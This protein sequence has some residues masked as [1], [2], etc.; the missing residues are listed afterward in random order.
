MTLWWGVSW[1]SEVDGSGGCTMS[2]MKPGCVLDVH[3]L[4]VSRIFKGT[5][6]EALFQEGPAPKTMGHK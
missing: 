3:K 5:K 6:V 1:E 4:D 2:D